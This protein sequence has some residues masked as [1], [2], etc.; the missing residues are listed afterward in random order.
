MTWLY[1]HS[2]QPCFCLWQF[3]HFFYNDLSY[4]FMYFMLIL[5]CRSI[6]FKCHLQEKGSDT[7]TLLILYFGCY[8]VGLL[9]A[10]APKYLFSL[11]PECLMYQQQK[12]LLLKWRLLSWLSAN[13]S[14]MFKVPQHN[15]L[16]RMFCSICKAEPLLYER[17]RCSAETSNTILWIEICAG[18]KAVTSLLIV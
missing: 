5:S 12:T 11:L 15:I 18:E 9:V 14:S 13:P 16:S 17:N 1:F 2:I 4:C 7:G 6:I 8:R 3:Q 10:V